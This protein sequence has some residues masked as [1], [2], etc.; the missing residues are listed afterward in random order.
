MLHNPHLSVYI[1]ADVSILSVYSGIILALLDLCMVHFSIEGL[2]TTC[3]CTITLE[4]D[5]HA[6][7]SEVFAL[8]HGRISTTISASCQASRPHWALVAIGAG[9]SN[10]LPVAQG[11]EPVR[12]C[13]LVQA[14]IGYCILLLLVP[15]MVLMIFL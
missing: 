4:S 5:A 11:Q 15:K 3:K 12:D 13:A 1:R 7:A 9:C 14:A 10:Q 8:I 2:C 6:S